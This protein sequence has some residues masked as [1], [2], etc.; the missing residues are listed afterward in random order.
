LGLSFFVALAIALMSGLYIT[1]ALG[2]PWNGARLDMAAAR[3]LY[4]ALL[5]WVLTLGLSLYR[6]S[7]TRAYQWLFYGLFVGL[8][9]NLH[10]LTG[11]VIIGALGML[12]LIGNL[13]G[14]FRLIYTVVFAVATLPGLAPSYIQSY[15]VL[16]DTVTQRFVDLPDIS[17]ASGSGL[18]TDITKANVFMYRLPN[19]GIPIAT[20]SFFTMLSS[21]AL[22]WAWWWHRQRPMLW[23]IIFGL[24]QFWGALVLVTVDWLLLFVAVE[25]V[26]RVLGKKDT[27]SES[28]ILL[29]LMA[30][31][32]MVLTIGGALTVIAFNRLFA[33]A[34]PLARALI[35]G[36]HLPYAPLILLL[37]VS[38]T[39]ILHDEL[40]RNRRL[41][42]LCALATFIVGIHQ[43]AHILVL[44]A[45]PF[46]ETTHVSGQW[47]PIDPWTYLGIF[48]LIL[49][50]TLG[51]G[52]TFVQVAGAAMLVFQAATRLL[53]APANDVT[54]LVIGIIAALLYSW[55][56]TRTQPETKVRYAVGTI[57]ASIIIIAL[58][59]SGQSVLGS[60]LTN[61]RQ[62][63]LRDWSR[64]DTRSE[65][66]PTYEAGTWLREHTSPDSLVISTS[67]YLR[68]WMLRPMVIGHQ[69]AGALASIQQYDSLKAEYDRLREASLDT[70]DL[71]SFSRNYD[72]DYLVIPKAP[73]PPMLEGITLVWES[74]YFLVYDLKH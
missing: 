67:T 74:D 4:L 44:E 54:T 40:H 30:I 70:E 36:G 12:M 26:R 6:R 25:W 19:W 45:I 14:R 33:P 66:F 65:F 42:F 27:S 8:L 15:L 47:L 60:V 48:L 73:S 41:F 37:G 68:Y 57:I 3:N 39:T 10:P 49:W 62:A 16:A 34:A 52:M 51:E 24:A 23:W 46:T 71:L 31:N 9:V 63:L 56:A 20:Y 22:M 53:S 2:A 11:P 35:R 43:Q 32:I 69:D 58:P 61:T 50:P 21:L 1:S 72:A 28:I 64:S 13:I 29:F 5:P 7:Q 55:S 38:L 18:F 17:V 59:I